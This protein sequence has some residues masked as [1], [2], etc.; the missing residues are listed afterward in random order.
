MNE[1]VLSQLV[2]MV[3]SRFKVDPKQLGA[4]DDL[5]E[6]LGI[7]SLQA[8]DL[9]GELELQF[10]VEIPDYVLKE[11]STFGGLAEAIERYK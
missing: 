8:L 5:F 3:A 7:D 11:A 1:A 4:E 10:G 6:R 9:L 2:Q